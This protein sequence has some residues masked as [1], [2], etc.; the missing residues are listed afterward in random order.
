MP[1]LQ[2]FIEFCFTEGAFPENCTIARIVLISKKGERDKPTNYRPIPI[3]TC[4]SR[5]FKGLIYELEINFLNKH[6]V[7]IK[8]QYG[9]QNKVSTNHAFV[10]IITNSYDNKNSNQFTGLFF[11][12]L[13]KLLIQ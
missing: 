3:F 1:H 12:T 4:F 7:I 8:T 5:I 13:L 10:D 6:S 9:F 11:L 2:V